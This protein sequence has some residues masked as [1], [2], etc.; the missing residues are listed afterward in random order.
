MY[1][2]HRILQ[3]RFRCH[4]TLFFYALCRIGHTY[5]VR[6]NGGKTGS[7]S[8]KAR[9]LNI[10]K[11]THF[12]F[13]LLGFSLS[14]NSSNRGLKSFNLW[15]AVWN[16]VYRNMGKK[17]T[18]PISS[19]NLEFESLK[20]HPILIISFLPLGFGLLFTFN[21]SNY[22]LTSFTWWW[23]GGLKLAVLATRKQ[24]EK[25]TFPKQLRIWNF[26]KWPI[27]HFCLKFFQLK[28]L[29]S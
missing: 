21:S 20:K 8:W 11:G 19:N 4:R 18:I 22:G 3:T 10:W 7:F 5:R 17:R 9:N 24:E 28:G 1:Q 6:G 15:L 16:C 12:S 26:G 13:L 29:W 2:K 27:S 23:F 25:T 14:Y